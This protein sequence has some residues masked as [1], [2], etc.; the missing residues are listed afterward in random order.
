MFPR[1]MGVSK[2]LGL[3][4]NGYL[5]KLGTSQKKNA[6]IK[7]WC[8]KKSESERL[9]II[10]QSS[11]VFFYLSSLSL[12]LSH[13]HHW[14]ITEASAKNKQKDSCFSFT[15]FRSLSVWA[16]IHWEFQWPTLL[17]HFRMFSLSLSLYLHIEKHK[18]KFIKKNH[19]ISFS[20]SQ[21]SNFW[22][23]WITLPKTKLQN[24]IKMKK[25]L[26]LKRQ[27]IVLIYFEKNVFSR[28]YIK[29]IIK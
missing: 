27:L 8:N 17:A 24:M 9:F 22:T 26:P 12:S 18:P 25:F 2:F 5:K 23:T 7:K 13:E 19:A 1:K 10:I 6:W 20:L 28:Y 15:C 3:H 21:E 16:S 29:I 11:C 14:Q 4:L